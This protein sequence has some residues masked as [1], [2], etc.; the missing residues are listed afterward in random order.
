[1]FKMLKKYKVTIKVVRIPYV[2]L[3]QTEIQC[4]LINNFIDYLI[5]H[6]YKVHEA[7]HK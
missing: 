3:K 7:N 2:F 6:E 4:I 1:M 5:S